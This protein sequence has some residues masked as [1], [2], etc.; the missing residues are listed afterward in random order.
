MCTLGPVHCT[1]D[2]EVM[3]ESRYVEY[4]GDGGRHW[5]GDEPK[6]TLL[7]SKDN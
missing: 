3:G 6:I 7:H 2:E 4:G 1:A 5:T